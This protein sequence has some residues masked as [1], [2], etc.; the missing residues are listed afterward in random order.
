M[1][2]FTFSSVSQPPLPR[3]LRP[4]SCQ[5]QLAWDLL[6]H[7][8]QELVAQYMLISL[9]F[10]LSLFI[11]LDPSFFPPPHSIPSSWNL[12]SHYLL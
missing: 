6:T 8:F 2:L 4:V 3:E 7:F 9:F 1:L 12:G 10:F 5:W 11:Q